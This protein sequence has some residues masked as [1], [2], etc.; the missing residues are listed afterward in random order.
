MEAC[1][2]FG[3]RMI[4]LDRPNPVNGRQLEG[5]LLDPEYSSFVGLYP[6]PMRHG[7]TTGELA[8]LF[9]AEFG[10]NCDLAVVEMEGWRREYWFDQ[11]G[12]ALGSALTESSNG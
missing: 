6:I 9:N 7:M 3:K 5:N 2:R 11:T 1:A 8:L 10:I 12:F 4:V